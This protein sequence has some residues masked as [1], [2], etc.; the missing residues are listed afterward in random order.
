MI[1][2]NPVDRDRHWSTSASPATCAACCLAPRSPA[3]TCSRHRRRS[4]LAHGHRQTDRRDGRSATA[5]SC[6][7]HCEGSEQWLEH[8]PIALLGRR[9]MP[10]RACPRS[11]STQSPSAMPQ[12]KSVVFSWTMGITHHVHGVENVQAI[13]N[14][15]FLRGM[16]GRPN[17][18]LLPIR[19]HSNVQGIG[20]GRRDA[21]T[22]GRDFRA[23]ANAFRSSRCQRPRGSTRW[24]AWKRPTSGQ[25]EDRFLSRRKSLRLKSRCDVCG[26]SR[27][28]PG[29]HG[30]T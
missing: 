11:K 3:F 14:L 21:E 28:A 29:K 12:P 13:A 20:L 5:T 16:V 1:V 15:A 25:A 9:F 23:V 8:T 7:T 30:V 6:Q 27:C 26:G 17:A 18:G 4:G 2:I 22:E 19:G 10:S 24:A